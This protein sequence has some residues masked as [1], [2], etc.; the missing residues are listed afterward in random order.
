M[1]ESPD[2]ALIAAYRR[3]EYR[4]RDRAY[5]F[6]LRVDD[7][8]DALRACHQDFGVHCSA[9][10][11]ACNPH[12]QPAS[13]ETNEAAMARLQAEL[14]SMGLP[15]LHGDGVDPTGDW[16]AEP[17]LLVMGLDAPTACALATRFD[18][19]AVLC[20]GDDAIPRLVSPWPGP[21]MKP[22]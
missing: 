20:A 3:T 15:Y 13:P 17:S 2:A 10:I 19:N 7:A 1:T 4:V 12:S 21:I 9:F 16:P 11:T 6:V 5:A 14:T 22:L 18:Q 8:S